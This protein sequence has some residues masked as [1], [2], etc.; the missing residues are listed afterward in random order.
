MDTI[1]VKKIEYA[2]Q[3]GDNPRNIKWISSSNRT[4]FHSSK[5]ANEVQENF[6]NVFSNKALPNDI[7]KLK[8]IQKNPY[9]Y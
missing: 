3:K 2:L 1:D 7:Q 6:I 5:L 4:Q 9:I 8:F